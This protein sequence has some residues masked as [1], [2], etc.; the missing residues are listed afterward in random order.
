MPWV[1]QVGVDLDYLCKYVG[2]QQFN[3]RREPCFRCKC[4]RTTIPWT[5]TR[6]DAAWTRCPRTH[7]VLFLPQMHTAF[8]SGLGLTVKRVSL[9]VMHV[10]DLGMCQYIVASIIYMNVCGTGLVG[11]LK[12]TCVVVCEQLLAA[13]ADLG[14]NASERFPFV[15]YNRFSE[16]SRSHIP[17]KPP[18]L[19]S[20]AAICHHCFLR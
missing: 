10:F 4:N 13:Y 6:P 16:N 14:T 3:G 1:F 20:M 7:A 11:N 12:D 15:S 19:H 8:D 5:D 2:L 17:T 9:D 18:H